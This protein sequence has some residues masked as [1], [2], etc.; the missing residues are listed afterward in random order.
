MGD[1]EDPSQIGLL[2]HCSPAF[3]PSCRRISEFVRVD[4]R[5]T[6]VQPS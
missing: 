5:P 1:R 6:R 2:D 3:Q 4:P